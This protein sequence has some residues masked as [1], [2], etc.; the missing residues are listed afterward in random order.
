MEHDQ[1]RPDQLQSFTLSLSRSVVFVCTYRRDK[2]Y[3]FNFLK[4]LQI[5]LKL[6]HEILKDF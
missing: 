5:H 1:S 6:F 3:F 2:K 4:N